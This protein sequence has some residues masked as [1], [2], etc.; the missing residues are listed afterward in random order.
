MQSNILLASL[1]LQ[2]LHIIQ[3]QFQIRLT[4]VKRDACERMVEPHTLWP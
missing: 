4:Y 1:K 2:I 3:L